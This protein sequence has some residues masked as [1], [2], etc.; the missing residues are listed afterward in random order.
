[1]REFYLNI[2]DPTFLLKMKLIKVDK[3]LSIQWNKIK[4]NFFNSLTHSY[5][6]MVIVA[7]Y[8]QKKFSFT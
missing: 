6:K 7:S 4:T 3:L 2:L 5:T 1:M 8:V